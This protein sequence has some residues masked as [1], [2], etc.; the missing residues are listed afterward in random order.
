MKH[1]NIE[2][3]HILV[4]RV[5]AKIADDYQETK[6]GIILKA[7]SP[8]GAGSRKMIDFIVE[9]SP[10]KKY[11][12]GTIIV[13]SEHAPVLNFEYQGETYTMLKR[14]DVYAHEGIKS[15]S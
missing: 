1:L 10:Y 12:A 7:D 4:S 11:P 2:K 9:N 3:P 13:A 6:S 5:Q 8:S 14:Q 15:P